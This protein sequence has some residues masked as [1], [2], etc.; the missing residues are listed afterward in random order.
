MDCSS[1]IAHTGVGY[2]FLCNRIVRVDKARLKCE[3]IHDS[4]ALG[5]L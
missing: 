3:N 4:G 5:W 1:S 2:Q